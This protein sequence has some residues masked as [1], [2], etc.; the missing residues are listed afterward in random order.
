MEKEFK[1]ID[2]DR[3]VLK[4]YEQIDTVDRRMERIKYD[5][6]CIKNIIEDMADTDLREKY[7]ESIKYLRAV[8]NNTMNA[9]NNVK[10]PDPYYM[11]KL[12]V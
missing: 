11:Y 10:K 12:K 5:L 1:Y 8:L 4:Y 3:D 9:M 6:I 7:E 2:L